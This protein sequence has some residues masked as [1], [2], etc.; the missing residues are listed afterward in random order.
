MSSG[1]VQSTA[2]V[3]SRKKNAAA[4]RTTA[5]TALSMTIAGTMNTRAPPIP[6]TS[7]ARR[8]NR[9]LPVRRK[10][11]SEMTP[12]S[13]SPTTPPINGSIVISAIWPG[14]NPRASD[15]YDGSHVRKTHSDQP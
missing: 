7:S 6:T 14:S 3:S 4:S 10:I 9:R 12:P 1:S 5:P 15:R 2:L 8:A 11:V 13:V